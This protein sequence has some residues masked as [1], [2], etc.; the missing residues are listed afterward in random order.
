ML[1]FGGATVFFCQL[2]CI[3]YMILSM[4]EHVG[5]VEVGS[6]SH[7]WQTGF[8]AFQVLSRISSINNMIT[9]CNCNCLVFGK[10]LLD[11]KVMNIS[12][13]SSNPQQS[14]APLF[15]FFFFVFPSFLF[16]WTWT[17]FEPKNHPI[18]KNHHLN[19][20]SILGF[21]MFF[22]QGLWFNG[23]CPLSKII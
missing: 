21:K 20:A 11:P 13:R 22:F 3:L 7:Y 4:E 10:T 6:L 9:C 15:A 16:S 5:P 19:R 17:V 2:Y 1:I 8:Y 23:P 14:K 12:R 18:P